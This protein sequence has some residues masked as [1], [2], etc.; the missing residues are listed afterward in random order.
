MSLE[1][2]VYTARAKATGGRDG[3][4][5]SDDQILDVKLAVPKEMGGPGGGT[6]P[7]QLFAAGYSA[8]FLGAMKFVANRD[9]INISKDAYIEGEVGI[10]PI[11][12]GFG[13]EVTLN[14]HLEG[15]KQEEA[16]KLVDAAHIVCPYSNATRNNIDVT[17]NVIT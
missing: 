3:R 13:I 8:C 2:A 9:K 16:Q 11:P 15:M 17:L 14:V 5:T 6:N 10:G 7:E 4:A 12:T 1:K